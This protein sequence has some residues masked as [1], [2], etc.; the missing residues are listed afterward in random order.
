MDNSTEI[1]YN[2]LGVLLL[3]NNIEILKF[4]DFVNVVYF[5]KYTEN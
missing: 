1:Y 3:I 5:A 2:G 4:V